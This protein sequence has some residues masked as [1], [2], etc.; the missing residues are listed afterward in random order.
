MIKLERSGVVERFKILDTEDP[1]RFK[2]PEPTHP[3]IHVIV[4]EYEREQ[5]GEEV[6]WR[7][8][9]ADGDGPPL[10]MSETLELEA[11]YQSQFADS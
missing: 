5:H 8:V 9:F 3:F 11:S 6:Y 1:D 10:S 2:P 7:R 4:A